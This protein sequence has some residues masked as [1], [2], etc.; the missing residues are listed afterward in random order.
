MTD[1][2]SSAYKIDHEEELP[3]RAGPTGVVDGDF[4]GG[5]PALGAEADRVF[6]PGDEAGVCEV[7]APSVGTLVP[8]VIGG[9]LASLAGGAAWAA[10]VV[11]SG[12][13]IGFAAV[14]IG[15]LSGFGVVLFSR[16]GVGP[17]FQVIAALTSVLGVA[18]GKYGYYAYYLKQAVAEEYGMEVAANVKLFSVGVLQSFMMDASSFLGGFDI[19]W[20]ALAV[21][22]AWK[23]PSLRSR[24]PDDNDTYPAEGPGL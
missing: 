15:F 18:A 1:G 12:Y 5:D 4:G 2:D 24:R 11:I 7:A 3:P 21:V 8:A 16:G 23:I 9:V 22:T 17:L 14:G 10:L 6:A 20:V 19:L 13:E